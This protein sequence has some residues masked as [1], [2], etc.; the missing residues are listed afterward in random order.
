MRCKNCGT[1]SD[2]RNLNC[3]NC[4]AEFTAE[5]CTKELT[6]LL[7]NKKFLGISACVL[8]LVIIVLLIVVDS[9][10]IPNQ[11]AE[12]MRYAFE[13][14]SGEKVLSVFTD[15]CGDYSVVYEDLS[16]SGKK[17][18]IEFKN[19]VSDLKD[20]L[21][22]QPAETDINNY[23]L[24]S[25]GDIVLPKEYSAITTIGQYN[26]ELNS[27]VVNYYELYLSRIAYE[28]GNK[29]YNSGNFGAAVNSFLRVI[30]YDYLYDDAQNKL[31]ESQTKMLE[32]KIALIEKYIRNGE[33][34]AAQ[35]QIF[36][37][38]E[39]SIT[40]EMKKKL[41]EYE[42]KIYEARL[43]KIDELIDNGDFEGANKYIESLGEGLSVDAKARLEQAI[44]N[45]ANDYI[46]NAD[47]ALK[48]G[49]RQGAYDMAKMAQNICPDDENINKRVCGR[50]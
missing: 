3:S 43:S 39:D 11:A 40:D 17:V 32:E 22:S 44:K 23:L 37:L 24:N 42:T 2:E 30:E 27:V 38:R 28:E 9:V 12:N 18:F 34:E 4:G 5:E 16:K 48:R 13:S 29:L 45:K 8:S 49:E 31:A 15:Y 20:D 26:I 41:D 47:E 21:N 7:K 36:D 6:D 46:K 25:T 35:Q 10:I 14:K 50:R 33:Y 1:E 19:C